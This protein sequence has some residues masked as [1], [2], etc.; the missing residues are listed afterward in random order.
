MDSTEART[1][2]GD[3]ITAMMTVDGDLERAESIISGRWPNA[4]DVLVSSLWQAWTS[5]QRC[6]FARRLIEVEEE[7]S[8]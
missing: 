2:L 5:D 3:V 4:E 6:R 8:G 7:T 1:I